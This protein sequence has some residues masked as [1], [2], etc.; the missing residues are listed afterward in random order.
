MRQVVQLWL[1]RQHVTE[2][3]SEVV[4]CLVDSFI[5]RNPGL[6]RVGE[7]V[8]YLAE[9]VE[10]AGEGKSHQVELPTDLVSL[11]YTAFIL[12]SGYASQHPRWALHTVWRERGCNS[13]GVNDLAKDY[14]HS[15]LLQGD[16]LAAQLSVPCV[17]WTQ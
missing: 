5:E 13:V 17:E 6:D 8:L 4:E 10:C 1:M 2:H 3:P 12:G 7:C 16:C 14:L 15:A 11:L 9:Q